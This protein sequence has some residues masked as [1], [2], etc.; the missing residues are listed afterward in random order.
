MFGPIA[1]VAFMTR[2]IHASMDYYA[3]K[4]GIGPWFFLDRAAQRGRYRGRPC[5]YV[6]SVAMADAGGVQLELMQ[7][8]DD[9]PTMYLEWARRP[10]ERE[11]QQHVCFWPDDYDATVDRALAAGFE[12]IQDGETPNGRFIYLAHPGG[13]DHIVEITEQTPARRAF[14]QGVARAAA[15]WD[16]QNPIRPY[17]SALDFAPPV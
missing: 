13:P 8:G 12:N 7:T 14:N 2:D 6:L 10:F 15:G 9:V 11:L 4:M 3:T 16:G 5:E 17:R 1:Q